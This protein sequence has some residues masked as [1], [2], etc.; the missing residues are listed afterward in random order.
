MALSVTSKFAVFTAAL[1]A[2]AAALLCPG[3][4]RVE[5]D[6]L[7]VPWQRIG[8][9]TLGMTA[10]D[11]VRVLGEPTQKNQ[12]SFVTVY[13]W[14]DDLTVTVKAEDSYV[15][16]ICALSPDYATAR[17]LRPGMS[18][19]SVTALMG[20]P[21]SSHVYR[22]WW[23][24]SYIKLFWGGLMVSVP[25]TGFDNNHSVQSVCVNHNA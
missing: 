23:K 3:L 9:V 17:G 16:E 20:E 12:R 18:D 14:K 22:G 6:H 1:F 4:A 24:L 7:I 10:D 5:N 8:P 15:T 11:V 21:Q 25:L 13:Y 2:I 19:T